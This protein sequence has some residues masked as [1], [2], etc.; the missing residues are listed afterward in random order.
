MLALSSLKMV[1]F[2]R[3]A[4]AKALIHGGARTTP[5]RHLRAHFNATL[6]KVMAGSRGGTAAP[7]ATSAAVKSPPEVNG[8]RD[9]LKEQ[10]AKTVTV[11]VSHDELK[12]QLVN[13]MVLR[14]LSAS[15]AAAHR[16]QQRSE[17]QLNKAAAEGL[18]REMADEA[19]LA[20]WE[21]S[22][23]TRS[24]S[25]TKAVPRHLKMTLDELLLSRTD[26]H[27]LVVVGKQN[28]GGAQ[29]EEEEFEGSDGDASEAR[30]AGQGDV[31]RVLLDSGTGTLTVKKNGML[32]EG[33]AG[34]TARGV[35]DLC[36][37]L[38]CYKGDTTVRIKAL[39]PQDF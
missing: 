39:S 14:S 11:A 9:E 31:I 1:V 25:K 12:E 10:L 18:A 2:G 15:A 30:H 28:A 4:F 20:A 35:G 13:N 17:F 7:F 38:S 32:L 6:P 24:P 19:A 23:G 26:A 36:W 8:H 5:T 34:R 27:R 29:Q 3:S 21:E 16:L 37:V 33:G 22:K